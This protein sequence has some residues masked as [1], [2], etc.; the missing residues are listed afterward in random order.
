M[1]KYKIKFEKIHWHGGQACHSASHVS[2]FNFL[3]ELI[4]FYGLSSL[5]FYE[6]I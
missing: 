5:N 2:K 4:N 6:K 1:K 3:E